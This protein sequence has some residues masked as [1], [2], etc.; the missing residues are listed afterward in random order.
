MGN[1][2]SK[3]KVLICG[4]GIGGVT[5]AIALTHFGFDV[6]VV[7]TASELTEVGAGIQLSPNAMHV[8][9]ELGVSEQLLSVG[10]EPVHSRIRHYK[11]GR[12]YVDVDISRL[13]KARYGAPYLHVHRADLLHVLVEKA[14]GCGVDF[15]LGIRATSY[16]IE[17]RGA[18]L[19]TSN[20]PKHGQFLVGC[21]GIHS[22]IRDQLLGPEKPQFTGQV[23]WRGTCKTSDLPEPKIPG[24]ATVW[25]GPGSHFVSYYVRSGS[26][27]NFVA[28]REIDDWKSESWTEAGDVGELTSYFADWHGPVRDIIGATKECH[29]W[30]LFDRP[31]LSHWCKGP[32][33][34]LGDAAHPMLPFMAQG[35][36]MAIEDAWVLAAVLASGHADPLQRYEAA[37][38]RRAENIQSISR[39]NAKL[40]HRSD[41][42]GDL[43]QRAKLNAGRMAPFLPVAQLDRIYGVNVTSAFPA[44]QNRV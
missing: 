16:E 27:V 43:W 19:H 17:G 29:L 8:M 30:G 31:P 5:A 37:R 9:Q 23:A 18:T 24:D 34:L 25:S 10:F 2:Y 41:G 1:D 40:F 22:V 39:K 42:L 13:A 4:A 6:E 28:V 33:A 15:S 44:A 14:R 35:A 32:V 11:T 12:I 26:L 7:E 21:D 3:T 36:A 38:K 20:G